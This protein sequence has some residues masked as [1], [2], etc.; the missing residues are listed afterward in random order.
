MKKSLPIAESGGVLAAVFAAFC[1]AGFPF[2]LTGLAAVGLTSIRRD[3]ILLP[4]MTA[5][6]LVALWGFWQGRQMHRSSGPLIV[7]AAGAACLFS[8]VVLIHG[9]PA[10]EFIWGGAIALF[11]ATVWNL[12][13][14]VRCSPP[15]SP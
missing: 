9:F 8:G 14:R 1:C 15:S 13:A 3:A 2:I 6:L 10:R 12:R 11:L 7:A 5:S 4:L